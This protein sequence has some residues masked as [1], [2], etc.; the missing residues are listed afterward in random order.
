MYKLPLLLILFFTTNLFAQK[1]VTNQ[2]D[3]KLTQI[4][5][6]Q[7]AKLAQYEAKIYNGL[8]D[9]DLNDSI[10]IFI[11]IFGK[12]KDY[13]S[14]WA[15][16]SK[17][18]PLI[19]NTGYYWPLTNQLYVNLKS[20]EDFMRVLVHEMS[21]SFM[22]HNIKNPPRWFNEGLAEFFESLQIEH[23]EV[24]VYIQTERIKAVKY[25]LNNRNIELSKFITLPDK[26]WSNKSKMND[27]YNTA[28]SLIL[29]ITQ[30]NPVL[31]QKLVQ[32]LQKGLSSQQAIEQSFGSM[33]QFE[34]DYKFYFK[35]H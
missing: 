10:T 13:R 17:G 15:Q 4:Q 8:F 32:N 2:V 34:H 14:A 28:Y 25:A 1:L 16:G 6:E 7:I 22:H 23:D 3:C 21:H 31:T 19:S 9:T 5:Q 24:Y 35:Y 27:L 26:E 11:N 30:Y 33:E 20:D 29:F 18:A 12:A